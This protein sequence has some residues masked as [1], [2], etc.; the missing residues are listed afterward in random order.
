MHKRGVVIHT[1][2]NAGQAWQFCMAAQIVQPEGLE[3]APLAEG[4]TA[5]PPSYV[6]SLLELS[7]LRKGRGSPKSAL[8]LGCIQPVSTFRHPGYF[9]NGTVYTPPNSPITRHHANL[10]L[11]PTWS[12]S[13]CGNGPHVQTKRKAL[14]S[15]TCGGSPKNWLIPNC[16]QDRTSRPEFL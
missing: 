11:N 12:S 6:F 1:M 4:C 13:L 14:S 8:G 7:H 10:S 9:L 3:L 5:A 15:I 16:I 2:L